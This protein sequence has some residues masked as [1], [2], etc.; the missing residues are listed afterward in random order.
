MSIDKEKIE[1]NESEVDKFINSVEKL[2]DYQQQHKYLFRICLLGDANVGKTSLLSRFCDNSF[3]ENYNNTI[4]VDFRLVTLKCNGYISKIH[5]WDT[6]GQERFRSLALNYLNNSHGFIFMY[7]ITDRDSFNNVVNW[8]DLA[9]EKNVKTIAN[10]LVGNKC[11]N[12]GKRQIS[13]EEGKNLAKDK[14]LFFMETSAKA[15]NNVQKLF[16]FFLYKLIEFYKTNNYV[17]EERL[18]LNKDNSEEI[19]TIRPTKKNCNC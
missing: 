6:A 3:K 11:D 18:V 15:N 8:I 17:E 1:E 14:N 5:I 12:E 9:L 19:S 2:N 7:D 4:G 13:I 16:Y 10:F